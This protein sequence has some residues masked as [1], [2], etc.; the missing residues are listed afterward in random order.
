[1]PWQ[2]RGRVVTLHSEDLVAVLPAQ[3]VRDQVQPVRGAVTQH[4]LLGPAA[5]QPGQQG[6]QPFRH[7]AEIVV[8]DPMRRGLERGRLRSRVHRC[9]GQRTLMGSVEPRAAIERPELGCGQ[10][11]RGQ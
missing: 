3:A 6:A 10:R 4:D 1:L 9:T 8:A 11:N 7:V 5:D 2:D